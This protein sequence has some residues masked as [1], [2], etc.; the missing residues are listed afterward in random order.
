MGVITGNKQRCCFDS[1]LRAGIDHSDKDNH[2]D[3]LRLVSASPDNTATTRFP[4]VSDREA[5]TA[6]SPG[7]QTASSSLAVEV[8]T[9][10]IRPLLPGRTIKS[11]ICVRLS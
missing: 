8:S 4:D 1:F 10:N 5:Q 7:A 2:I 3:S 6:G 11:L 9:M